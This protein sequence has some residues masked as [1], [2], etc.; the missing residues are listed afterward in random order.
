MKKAKPKIVSLFS[1]C[2]GL[3]LGFVQ[4]GYEIVWAND[5]FHSACETYKR[6]FGSHIVEKD[7]AEIDFKSIPDCDLI[8]GGFPCQDFSMIWKRGGIETERGN[9]YRHFVRAVSEKLP[10]AF[11]AENVKGLLTANK[12]QAIKQIV[13]DFQS[14]DH[15]GYRI[16]I[17]LFNFAEY[18]VPQL[19]QRV[20]IVGIRKDIPY[21]FKKPT[22][23]YNDTNYMT[24][25]EALKDVEKVPYNNEEIKI[26]ERTKKI[27]SLIPE[28]GNFTD[29]PK[30]SPYYVKGMISHVYRRLNKNRPSTTII[31]GGGGGT[32]GYHY[33][34]P[35]PLTNRERARLFGYPDDFVFEGSIAEV[36]KQIGN[37]V[38]PPAAGFVAKELLRL[39]NGGYSNIN[40]ETLKSLSGDAL[41][42]VDFSEHSQLT[43]MR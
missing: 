29:I 21:E 4:E 12:G 5:F 33:A 41:A 36:R 2:G 9:L 6:N 7:I 24:A 15:S 39:F 26:K 34:E 32:W 16:Y 40:T 1:G 11:I 22:P 17:N 35:R 31:A 43:L 13:K 3:D 10:K 30:D 37:S 14:I 38:P 42:Y 28:G 25:G 8:T 20:I 18:G 23:T 19:R 27:I